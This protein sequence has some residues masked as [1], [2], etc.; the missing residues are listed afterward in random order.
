[1]R[2]L[3]AGTLTEIVMNKSYHERARGHAAKFLVPLV[4][5]E[6]G[7][8]TT[9]EGVRK[10]ARKCLDLLESYPKLDMRALNM[11]VRQ[12]GPLLC[13]R[14]GHATRRDQ[15]RVARAMGVV[16]LHVQHLGRRALDMLASPLAYV[17]HP[18]SFDSMDTA[19]QI[20][21]L[22]ALGNIKG[23]VAERAIIL[24]LLQAPGD[25]VPRFKVWE[26]A[27]WQLGRIGGEQ[28][29]VAL[30][31]ALRAQGP[32]QFARTRQLAV[33]SLA[34]IGGPSAVDALIQA[35]HVQDMR[36]SRPNVG[37]VPSDAAQV[38][39][40]IGRETANATIKATVSDA[41]INA[42]L[43]HG[44]D[45]KLRMPIADELAKIGGG[46]ARD[47]L[48][49][50]F[51]GPHQGS[52]E[53]RKRVAEFLP[54]FGDEGEVSSLRWV[55]FHDQSRRV[56]AEAARALGQIGGES[57]VSDLASV[58]L[59]RG[60]YEV[61]ESAARALGHIGDDRAVDALVE[62]VQ[63][64]VVQFDKAKWDAQAAVS[65]LDEFDLAYSVGVSRI[66]IDQLT[67]IGRKRWVPALMSL[68][69][70]LI[71]FLEKAQGWKSSWSDAN[72]MVK[73]VLRALG[74]IGGEEACQSLR[75]FP[76]GLGRHFDDIIRSCA[77]TALRRC[78]DHSMS[79]R[80]S[81]LFTR[82]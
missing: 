54:M 67:H 1:M 34:R 60:H 38:L 12:L 20:D 46:G 36:P 62:D 49:Q 6:V 82:A 28:S 17:L 80:Q 41:L 43:S 44:I 75:L 3:A 39:G 29:V 57:A 10:S 64:M 71:L 76:E 52:V 79:V 47:A 58:L 81:R 25:N 45:E 21:A 63:A 53:V 70:D 13:R 19:L 55:L 11:A 59:G 37:W 26:E 72:G 4:C 65:S 48:V 31:W 69:P 77:E 51:T 14:D 68:V 33:K 50:A 78:T 2:G 16:G 18:G 5:R 27:A 40:V 35:M 24:T 9:V 66:S 73:G 32:W 74:E 8:S 56:R 7:K 22:T 23:V 15:L 30:V 61:R 42:F